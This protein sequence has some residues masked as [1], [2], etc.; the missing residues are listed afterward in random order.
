M[1]PRNGATSGHQ[2][3]YQI[4]ATCELAF[5]TN[6]VCILLRFRDIADF[7]RQYPFSLPHPYSIWIFVMIPLQQIGNFFHHIVKAL[8]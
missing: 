5:N 7:S 3:L 6:C 2:S 8:C 1:K 4:N